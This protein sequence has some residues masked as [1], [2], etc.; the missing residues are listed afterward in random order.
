MN[1]VGE[2]FA[3]EIIKQI[4]V[5]Q[6]I[7]GSIN[8]TNEQLVYLNTRTGWCKLVSSVNVKQSGIRGVPY[9]ENKLAEKFVLFNGVTNE[10]PTEGVQETYQRSGIWDGIGNQNNFAYGIGGTTFG[11]KPMPGI[12]SADIKTETRGS[13]KTATIQIKANSREQ[14]D[15]IDVLYLRLGYSMLL[16]W[17]NNSYYDNNKTFIPDNSHSLADDFLTGKITYSNYAKKIKDKILKSCGNYD[18]LIGKVVNFNWSFNQDGSY[19]ITLILR[20][21]GDII[22][23][24]KANTLLP[25]KVDVKETPSTDPTP[26][27]PTPETVIKSFANTH[28]IGRELYRLQQILQPLPASSNGMSTIYIEGTDPTNIVAFKQNYQNGSTQYYVQLSYLLQYIQNNILPYVEQPDIP[29]QKIDYDVKSNIIYLMPRQVSNRPDVCLFKTEFSTPSGFLSFASQANTF[30]VSAPLDV[31]N[32]N[33]KNSNTYGYIM[34]AYFNMQWILTTIENKKDNEGKVSLY[35]LLES[36]CEGWNTSTGNFNK[37]GVTIDADEGIIRLIDQLPLPDKNTWLKSFKKPIDLAMFNVYGIY[38]DETT[39]SGSASFIKDISF[40]TTVPPNLATMITIGSTAN[41]YVVGQDST[42]LSRMNAGL[43]DRFKKSIE[44][45]NDTKTVGTS[46]LNEN[47]SSALDAYNVFLR[48]LGSFKNTTL[49]KWNQEAI[50]NF[51]NT[52]TN[53]YEYDQAKQTLEAS[54]LTAESASAQAQLNVRSSS[55]PSSPNAGFLPFDL[56]LTMDG[57]SGMKVYQKYTI[58]TTYLPSNYPTSLEFLIK[59]I[60]NKIENN[61]WTTTLESIAVPKNPFGATIGEN[62]IEAGSARDSSRGTQPISGGIIWNN[63]NKNQQNNAIYL[64]NTLISY[65]FSDIEARAILGIVAKESKFSPTNESS[66]KGTSATR[67]KDIFPTAFKNKS[68]EF[69]NKL[70]MNDEEFFDFLYGNKYGNGPKEGFKYRGRGFN[71]LT[72]KSNYELYNKLYKQQGSK[73]GIIDIVTNPDLVNK[74][75]GGIYKIASHLCALYFLNE[76]N[77]KA[78]KLNSNNFNTQD[79]AIL[80]YQRFNSGWGTS[81]NGY[82]FQEGLLKAKQFVQTIP[83]NIV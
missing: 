83:Q 17:G 22:E 79:N 1:I 70:K 78:K 51:S 57:L 2:G 76:K 7:Y 44:T 14:F 12:I 38:Y 50:N 47:Y 62:T 69:I 33:K 42:A 25:G 45:R 59:G 18:A 28:D 23:S 43:E 67:I 4:N 39:K 65:G 20:S 41:G 55:S 31:D 49:P 64:Y 73:A 71:G 53:F 66:Y 72:F 81:Q 74:S 54:G 6:D 63:L 58:D 75:E 13:L 32:T 19:S 27:E 46:S 48:D 24:L 61:Q 26:P 9:T 16:E 30:L 15:I 52:A 80:T 40:T 21:L 10:S 82:T 35:D 36:L 34:N 29:I 3:D 60:T 37:L 68:D 8:R 11:L 5:R 77:I 56:S